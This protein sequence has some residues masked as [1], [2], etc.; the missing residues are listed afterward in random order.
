V[1]RFKPRASLGG[2]I[3]LKEGGRSDLIRLER[4]SIYSYDE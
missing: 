2:L 1:I 3:W 4:E